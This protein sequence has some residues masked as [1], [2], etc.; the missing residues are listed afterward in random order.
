[1]YSLKLDLNKRILSACKC[2]EGQEYD[3]VVAQLPIGDIANYKYIDGGFIY[4]PLPVVVEEERA[5]DFDKLEAQIMYT[6]MMTDT[7]LEV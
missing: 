7:L 1:M 4:D 6:A 2:F 3:N 5:S